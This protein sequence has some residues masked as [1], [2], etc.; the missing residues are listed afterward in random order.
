MMNIVT[1]FAVFMNKTI[2]PMVFL[3]HTYLIFQILYYKYILPSTIP[4]TYRQHFRDKIMRFHHWVP[5]YIRVYCIYALFNIPFFIWYEYSYGRFWYFSH[6][7]YIH[8]HMYGV[9]CLL[10]AFIQHKELGITP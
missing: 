1:D 6:F 9:A 5:K 8:Y 2:Y 7:F 3:G 4:S 10:A